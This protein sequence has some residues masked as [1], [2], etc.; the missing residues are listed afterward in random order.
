MKK[1]Q[2]KTNRLGLPVLKDLGRM[3]L[4]FALVVFG[5]II[6]RAE[7]IGEAWEYMIHLD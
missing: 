6:F 1:T 7:N 4:T 5:G 2:L 3:L